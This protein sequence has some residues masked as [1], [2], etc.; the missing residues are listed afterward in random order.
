MI[1]TCAHGG[2]LPQKSWVL[3]PDRAGGQATKYTKNLDF[4]YVKSGTA[5]AEGIDGNGLEILKSN[6]DKR[7]IFV[8]EMLEH[9]TLAMREQDGLICIDDGIAC[10]FRSDRKSADRRTPEFGV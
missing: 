6:Y 7:G 9:K 4:F 1:D 3:V 8:P 10:S 5:G 2:K